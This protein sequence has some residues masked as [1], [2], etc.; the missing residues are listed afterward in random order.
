MDERCQTTKKVLGL[1]LIRKTYEIP[2]RETY[3]N[4]ILIAMEVYSLDDFKC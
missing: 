2:T 4:R 1:K 3:K